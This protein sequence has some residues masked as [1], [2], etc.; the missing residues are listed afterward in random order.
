M[1][2]YSETVYFSGQNS[3]AIFGNCLQEEQWYEIVLN[4]F[5]SK[6]CMILSFAS[7]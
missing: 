5:L 6:A 3:P 2:F 4:S 1:K 7:S